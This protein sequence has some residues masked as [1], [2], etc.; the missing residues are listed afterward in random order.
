MSFLKGR[1]TKR[2]NIDKITLKPPLV[3]A[4]GFAFM[5]LVGGLFLSSSY[6]NNTGQPTNLLDSIFVA[7]SASCVTGLTPVNTLEHWNFYGQ[8]I[9]IVLVQIG[10]LGIMTAATILPIIMRQRIGLASRQILTEQFN[11]DTF[12]GVVKMFKYAL[13]F[14]FF[15]EALGALLFSI[16]FIPMYG[17]LKG[18]WYSI[19]HSISAF[20]NSGFDLFGDSIVPFKN[21][22]LINLTIMMLIIV[23]GLGFMVTAELYRK[24]SIKGLSVHTRIVLVMTVGLILLGTFGFLLLEYSNPETIAQEAIGGKLLQSS[25]QSVVARTAGFY[26]VRLSSLRESTVFLLIILMFIGGAPGSTAGGLKVTT[27]GVL[28]MA[29][30]AVIKGEEEPVIFNKHIG[31][32]TIAK[33]LALVM[34]CLGIVIS[35]TFILT[36]TENFKFIDLLYEV[37]SAFSTVGVTRNVTENLTNVGKII[38]ILNMYIGRVGPLTLAYAFGSKAKTANIRYPEANISIG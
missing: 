32:K 17:T 5:I 18:L 28:I 14:T 25:F 10:G 19:F 37:V 20:C 31:T 11:I 13:S 36:L 1:K 30:I 33:A 21:D 16:R 38:I 7:G 4:L 12:S 9:I 24:R 23:G 26:S 29:T 2:S 8:L 6:V 3:L 35:F 15:M 34:I 22:P 27:F